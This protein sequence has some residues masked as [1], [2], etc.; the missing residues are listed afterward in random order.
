MGKFKTKVTADAYWW[1]MDPEDL[2]ARWEVYLDTDIDDEA[3][4]LA[5]AQS[6]SQ[7]KTMYDHAVKQCEDEKRKVKAKLAGVANA[8]Q[9]QQERQTQ[10]HMRVFL[11]SLDHYADLIEDRGR[12]YL[13]TLE[14]KRVFNG[15]WDAPEDEAVP[16]AAAEAC[17]DYKNKHFGADSKAAR[18]L[19]RFEDKKLV[20]ALEEKAIAHGLDTPGSFIFRFDQNVGWDSE[21][22]SRDTVNTSCIRVDSVGSKQHSHPFPETG[23]T[24]VSHQKL[25]CIEIRNAVLKEDIERLVK[26]AKYLTTIGAREREFKLPSSLQLKKSDWDKV[27]PCFF[28]ND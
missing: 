2:F 24:Y 7:E 27:P 23:M 11:E 17:N 12:L 20:K 21:N 5:G 26:I 16:A 10:T 4:A 22:G 25:V 19:G 3:S 15:Q 28:W 13:V 18:Y 1:Q 14:T 9:G 6:G 8:P